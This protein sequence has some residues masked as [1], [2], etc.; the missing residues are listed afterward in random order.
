MRRGS[1]HLKVSS[2]YKFLIVES[3]SW[4]T[5]ENLCHGYFYCSCQQASIDL[6]SRFNFKSYVAH[7]NM[8]MLEAI[9]KLDLLINTKQCTMYLHWLVFSYFSAH[10]NWSKEIVQLKEHHSCELDIQHNFF[11]KCAK[12]LQTFVE[13]CKSF[14][15]FVINNLQL[16]DGLCVHHCWNR[17]WSKQG[18]GAEKGKTSLMRWENTLAL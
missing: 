8:K 13:V 4:I 17:W 15:H 2:R 5:R 9:R 10:G 7:S 11:F 1:I 6:D 16:N 3:F 12:A 18:E 14:F